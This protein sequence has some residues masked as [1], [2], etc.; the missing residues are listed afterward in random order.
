MLESIGQ[1]RLDN[2]LATFS[3]EFAEFRGNLN[4]EQAFFN[5]ANYQYAV[6]RQYLFGTYESATTE[7]HPDIL[8]IRQCNR[9]T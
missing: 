4:K 6:S 3:L 1:N 8:R 9:I 7:K 5:L 2:I